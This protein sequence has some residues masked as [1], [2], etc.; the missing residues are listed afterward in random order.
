SHLRARRDADRQVGHRARGPAAPRRR[1]HRAPGPGLPYRHRPARLRPVHPAGLRP[2]RDLQALPP[3]PHRTRGGA[4]VHSGR[5][6]GAAVER[7]R[8]SPT[9]HAVPSAQGRGVAPLLLGSH[10]TGHLPIRNGPAGGSS[11]WGRF[12]LILPAAAGPIAPTSE[13]APS[14][15]APTDRACPHPPLHRLSPALFLCPSNF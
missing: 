7:R 6:A 10:L 5:D 4:A 3:A 9:V 12:V 11:P 14:L 1:R 13:A 15:P 2:A 8:R